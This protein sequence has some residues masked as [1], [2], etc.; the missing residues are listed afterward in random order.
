MG[1]VR[2][3]DVRLQDGRK[4]PSQRVIL[5]FNVLSFKLCML[6]VFVAMTSSANQ[7]ELLNCMRRYLNLVAVAQYRASSFSFLLY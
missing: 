5:T 7:D 2:C 1:C 6:N 3:A 4:T